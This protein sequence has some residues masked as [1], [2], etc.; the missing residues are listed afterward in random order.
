MTSKTKKKTEVCSFGIHQDK[1]SF[2]DSFDSKRSYQKYQCLNC[3]IWT[4][5]DKFIPV[6]QFDMTEKQMF[7]F[8]FCRPC[9]QSYQGV[10]PELRQ[11]FINNVRRKITNA[12]EVKI[13]V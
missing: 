11:D 7:V 12:S 6:G 1:N 5:G 10:S 13:D 9:W 2:F 8:R 3:D 4:R